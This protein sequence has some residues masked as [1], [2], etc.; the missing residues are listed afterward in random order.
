MKR[1]S[2]VLMSVVCV[3][4][5]SGCGKKT[6]VTS[7]EHEC[8]EHD[9]TPADPS[10]AAAP[11]A[12]NLD[13]EAPL[14]TVEGESLTRGMAM[15]MARDM[16]ARQGVPP[17]MLDQFLSQMGSQFEKQA[18]DQFISQTLVSKEA[19]RRDI[20]VTNE[21][22]D[23]VLANIGSTL[24]EGVTLEQ[25]LQAQNMTV[26]DFR[27]TIVANERMRK[28]FEAETTEAEDA[29]DAQVETF[30]TENAQRFTT[31]ESA[32]ASHILISCDEKAD[33]E[34]HAK[35]EADLEAVK[36]TLA[37]GGDFAELAKVHSSCPSKEQGGSL[38]SFTRGRMVPEFEE[39]AFSMELGTVSDVVKTQFGYHLITVTER[40]EASSR[41]LEEVSEEIRTHLDRQAEGKLFEVFVE[42]LKEGAEITYPK[43]D[44]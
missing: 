44:A 21:E 42:G 31:E 43:T 11:Q 2:L 38:G 37:E 5:M 7:A 35:A 41:P 30:Y 16:A 39:A 9:H 26:A 4:F 23:A 18:I 20:P 8:T 28:L 17:Q 15:N 14:V 13:M 22:I 36:V 33:E 40:T 24:P 6:E 1:D 32:T 34:A 3:V 19:A 29:T 10:V 27:A 25:A 12:G